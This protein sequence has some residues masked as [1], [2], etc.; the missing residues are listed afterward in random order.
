VALQHLV[1]LGFL[2]MKSRTEWQDLTG[3]AIHRQEQFTLLALQRL[4]ER[5]GP[6]R[7]ASL[8]HEGEPRLHG[9]V[10]VSVTAAEL[11]RVL[12]LAEDFL[13][14]VSA[15]SSA[16]GEQLYQLEIHCYPL[17]SSKP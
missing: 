15:G 16:A 12:A 6:M 7:E 9:T 14:E 2:R 8:R 17:S 4:L 3:G 13:R 10:T 1:R 5:T 11:A